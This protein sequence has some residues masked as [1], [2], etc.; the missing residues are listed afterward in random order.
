MKIGTVL[1]LE[2]V[3]SGKGRNHTAKKYRCKV[4]DKNEQNLYIDFPVDI[5]SKKTAFFAKGT[6]FD[7]T[8]IGPDEVIYQFRSKLV[9]KVKGKIPALAIQPPGSDIRRIQRRNFARVE[10]VVDVAVHSEQNLFPPFTTVTNDISGGG[11]SIIVP[12]NQLL[13]GELAHLWMVLAMANGQFVYPH[14]RA[15][16]VHEQKRNNGIL[17]ASFQFLA[18]DVKTEQWIIRFCFE[19]QREARRK[20]LFHR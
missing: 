15:K 11:L 14:V 5:K 4:V 19:K 8:F 10:T 3:K 17:I 2:V 7:V 1:Q 12:K 18:L 9:A 20:Q 13:K 6:I 16:L